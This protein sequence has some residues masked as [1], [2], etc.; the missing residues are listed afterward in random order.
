VEHVFTGVPIPFFNA[1]MVTGHG[2][3][4][5]A[6][7]AIAR[8]ACE[9]AAPHCVPW[10][11]VAT[12]EALDAGVDSAATLD[13]CGLAPLMSL[14]GMVAEEVPSAP[15]PDGLTLK[16]AANDSECVAAFD[17]NG[18]AYAMPFEAA[19]PIWGKRSYWQ[20]HSL[21]LGYLD[22]QP[23]S[24][25]AALIVDGYRYVALVATQ[26]DHR[27]RGYADAAM[28]H[29]LEDSRRAHGNCPTFLH[30]TEAGR[31]VYERMG[32]RPVSTHHIFMEKRF[33]H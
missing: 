32:Y 6:L 30:A 19:N 13:A 10:L 16:I 9:W 25:A 11:L 27:R 4:A 17:I 26:P 18:V 15:A 24:A 12:E 31:P 22:N 8:G 20:N 29:A 1:S 33:L 21:A 5:G 23:V 7:V 2:H 14:T 3:S 28:R